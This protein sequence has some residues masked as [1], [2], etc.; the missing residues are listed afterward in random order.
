[1]EAIGIQPSF[2]SL[3]DQAKGENEKYLIF[4][5]SCWESE[6]FKHNGYSF[7]KEELDNAENLQ[8]KLIGIKNGVKCYLPNQFI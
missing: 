3:N 1:M 4:V 2:E 5:R 8:V 7:T 6:M